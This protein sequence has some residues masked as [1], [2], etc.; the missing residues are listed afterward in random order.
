MITESLCFNGEVCKINC[1]FVNHII[2]VILFIIVIEDNAHTI[3]SD[4]IERKM[5][6]LNDYI[7]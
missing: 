6:S 4:Y 3:V 7:T 2:L 5:R 1:N